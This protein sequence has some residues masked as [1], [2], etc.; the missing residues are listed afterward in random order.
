M[1]LLQWIVYCKY[2][3]WND[4]TYKYMYCMHYSSQKKLITKPIRVQKNLY[5]L[6]NFKTRQEI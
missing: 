4:L 3:L 2:E 1:Q 6:F 5:I